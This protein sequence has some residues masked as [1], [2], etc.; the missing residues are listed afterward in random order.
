MK[1]KLTRKSIL[2]TGLAALAVILVLT[3]LIAP[4]LRLTNSPTAE[5]LAIPD[6]GSAIVTVDDTVRQITGRIA[7]DSFGQIS[8][9][10]DQTG[11]VYEILASQIIDQDQLVTFA[12]TGPDGQA[13]EIVGEIVSQSENGTS[14]VLDPTTGTQYIVETTLLKKVSVDKTTSTQAPTETTIAPTTETLAPTTNTTEATPKP[15]ESSAPK[16][17]TTTTTQPTTPPTTVPT[18]QVT[19]IAPVVADEITHES[20]TVS[21]DPTLETAYIGPTETSA[22]DL[23]ESEAIRMDSSYINYVFSEINRTRQVNGT[24]PLSLDSADSGYSQAVWAYADELA[25]GIANNAPDFPHV[26]IMTQA[27]G[28]AGAAKDLIDVSTAVLDPSVHAI[29]ISAVK[30]SAS[31]NIYL[32][33]AF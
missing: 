26:W 10:D 33:I 19:T 6:Y 17:T 13:D 14:T 7:V 23:P 8:I 3:F 27:N 20:Y 5:T 22:S 30:D 31:R 15:T 1:I 9:Q 25:W 24:D 29:A 28:G 16:K 21:T 32:V 11:E 4:K 18:T 12:T 2:I